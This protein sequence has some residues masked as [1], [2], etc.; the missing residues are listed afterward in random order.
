MPPSSA[1][2]PTRVERDRVEE[3]VA[4]ERLVGRRAEVPLGQQRDVDA[5]G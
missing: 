4:G 2:V 5:R 1:S 3:G